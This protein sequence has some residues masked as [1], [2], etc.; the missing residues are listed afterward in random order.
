MLL[1]MTAQEGTALVPCRDLAAGQDD[2]VAA[3]EKWNSRIED[4]LQQTLE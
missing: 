4:A 3:A 2:A 1:G